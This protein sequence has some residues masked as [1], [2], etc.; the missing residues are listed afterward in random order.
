FWPSLLEHLHSSRRTNGCSTPNS[1][2][3]DSQFPVEGTKLVPRGLGSAEPRFGEP[4]DPKP[5][6]V[7]RPRGAALSSAADLVCYVS[8]S[9]K[10][11]R[12]IFALRSGPLDNLRDLNLKPVHSRVGMR[13]LVG[14]LTLVELFD[15][16]GH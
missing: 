14:E 13:P 8:N 2:A 7:R 11:Q 9:I 15:D 10:S 4:R 12:G 1:R 6:R 5:P 3:S 16:R